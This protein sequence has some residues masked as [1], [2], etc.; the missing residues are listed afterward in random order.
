MAG[1]GAV[2]ASQADLIPAATS[3][4]TGMVVIMATGTAMVVATAGI[5]TGTA[6]VV[7]KANNSGFSVALS[8]KTHQNKH[9]DGRTEPTSA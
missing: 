6:M 3:P 2:A 1:D 5:I 4:A 9:H 7:V 8:G